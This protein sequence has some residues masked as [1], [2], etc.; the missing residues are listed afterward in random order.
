[1]TVH[2]Q[3]LAFDRPLRAV[4]LT[5]GAERVHTPAELTAARAQGYHDGEEAARAFSDQQMVD[6]RAEGQALRDGLFARLAEVEKSLVQQVKEA[7]PQL[8]VE[9][10]GRLLGG[11]EPPPELVERICREAL[12]QLYPERSDLELVVGERD[13]ALLD[14]LGTDWSTHF[15]GLRITIDDTLGPGDCLVRSRFGVTDARGA[16]KLEGLRQEL[17]SS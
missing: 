3:V 1:M 17:L 5:H 16:V 7:L 12:E 13:A 4:Q 14:N 6:L 8:A 9:L 11:F 2:N 15:P 10:G